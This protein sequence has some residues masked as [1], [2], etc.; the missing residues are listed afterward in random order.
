M[1]R[2][3]FHQPINKYEPEELIKVFLKVG[4]YQMID[5]DGQEDL[6]NQ[7][8][9][10]NTEDGAVGSVMEIHVPV[11]D[12]DLENRKKEKGV[13]NQVKRFLYREL[14]RYTGET[15]DWGILT[16]VRP[17]KLAGELLEREE[18]EEKAKEVLTGDYYLTEEK[19]RLLLDIVAYQRT[20]PGSKP[21]RSGRFVHRHPVLPDPMRLLLVPVQPGEGGKHCGV[22]DRASPR[23]RVHFGKN[24]GKQLVS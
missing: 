12:E 21:R 8:C 7:D 24:E 19:A 14:Q 10:D 15:P 23:D 17:V 11:F 2:I 6:E 1:Y 22:S 3:H 13:K 5:S 20:V 4:D 18:M 16:G 9:G